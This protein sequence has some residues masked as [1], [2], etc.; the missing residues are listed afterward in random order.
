[1]SYSGHASL[2]RLGPYVATRAFGRTLMRGLAW[3]SSELVYACFALCVRALGF[4]FSFALRC[5]ALL[6]AVYVRMQSH[7]QASQVQ[8]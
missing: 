7:V 4:W 1:M 6:C 2:C 8:K 5:A 3:P